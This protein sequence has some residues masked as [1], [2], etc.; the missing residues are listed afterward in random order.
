MR[1]LML[2]GGLVLFAAVLWR[3]PNM[4]L[5]HDEVEHLHAAWLVGQGDLP[6][7]DFAE[8]HN[9]VL[10]YLL[11]PLLKEAPEEAVAMGRALMALCSLGILGLGWLL[12]RHLGGGKGLLAPILL[13]ASSYWSV[14]AVSIR[15]DVPMT[16]LLLLALSLYLP[17]SEGPPPRWRPFAAGLA[18][19]AAVAVLLKA[20]VVAAVVIGGTLA[21]AAATRFRDRLLAAALM[22]SGLALPIAS[23]A[24][25]MHKAGVLDGAL[26]WM[27]RL[28]GPYLLASDMGG[29]GVS[30]VLLASLSRDPLPW[31]T[32]AL[33]LVTFA[34]HPSWPR[35]TLIAAFPHRTHGLGPGRAT[36]SSGA[37]PSTSG[38]TTRSSTRPCPPWTWDR[39]GTA[40]AETPSASRPTRQR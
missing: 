10:W 7:Q 35:A 32:F 24:L 34:M 11:A 13:A 6:Y 22:L 2:A 39:H 37:T 17:S 29:F 38:S 19:G 26:L 25:A 18:M 20:A 30:D 1:W 9:P 27:V 5:D 4:R 21:H 28:Q 3:L 15:P 33:A 23:L 16:T 36:P 31:A 40:S 8:T 12:A 14:Y